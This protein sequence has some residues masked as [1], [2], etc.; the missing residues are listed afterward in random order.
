MV[1]SSQIKEQL[2]RFL[3][4]QISLDA[5]EDWFVQNTWNV[6]LSDSVAAENLTFAVEE[7]LSEYSSQHINEQELRR[8]L[9][10]LIHRENKVLIA[11]TVLHRATW[12]VTSSRPVFAPVF[13]Q[14]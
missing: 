5:F 6:H 7:S 4:G 14:L 1:S 12:E 9:S 8:E 11:S 2:A 3:D 10:D 13:A